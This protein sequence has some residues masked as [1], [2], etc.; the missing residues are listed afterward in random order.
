VKSFAEQFY[1]SLP[2]IKGVFFCNLTL[3]VFKKAIARG[4]LSPAD[5]LGMEQTVVSCVRPVRFALNTVT[6]RKV[7]TPVKNPRRGPQPPQSMSLALYP[8]S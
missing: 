1:N 3:R 4:F 7:S 8:H 6:A 5:V 2:H